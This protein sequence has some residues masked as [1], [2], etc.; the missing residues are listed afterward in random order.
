M[1]RKLT[2]GRAALKVFGVPFAPDADSTNAIETNELM[3]RK[4]GRKRKK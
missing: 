2:G 4:R 3:K 1:D